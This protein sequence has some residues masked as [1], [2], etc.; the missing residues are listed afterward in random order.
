MNKTHAKFHNNQYKSVRGVALTRGTHNLN[1][2]GKK[3]KTLSIY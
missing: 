3:E 1:I 2:E